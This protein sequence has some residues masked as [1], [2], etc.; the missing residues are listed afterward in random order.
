MNTC[1]FNLSKTKL[2]VLLN[3]TVL[4]FLI[5]MYSLDIL[6]S[7][8]KI[9]FILLGANQTKDGLAGKSNAVSVL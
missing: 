8:E 6:L 4:V 2:E 3:T 5:Q 9:H 1:P 7:L